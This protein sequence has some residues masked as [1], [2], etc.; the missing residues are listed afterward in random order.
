MSRKYFDRLLVGTGATSKKVESKFG[1]ALMAKMGWKQGDGL[2]KSMDGMV[3][4][5]QIKRRDENLGMGA[6]VETVSAKFK[7]NDQFWD[8]NYNAAA[9]KFAANVPKT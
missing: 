3:D 5:I 7:W 2:G 4:P 1:E 9:A 6:E 8:D